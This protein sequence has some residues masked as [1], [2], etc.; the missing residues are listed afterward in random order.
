[1][2]NTKTTG[3]LTFGTR[4][5]C[6]DKE[7][8][9]L[10]Y[11]AVDPATHQV[12][13]IVAEHG[14]PFFKHNRVLPFTLI[15]RMAADA[16]QLTINSAQWDDYQEYRE[17]AIEEPDP[18]ASAGRQSI[19]ADGALDYRVPMIHRRLRQGIMA[20]RAI[21]HAGT[22]VT[23]R[24]PIAHSEAVA[25]QVD[26][27]LVEETTGRISHLALRRGLL[28]REYIVV[29]IDHLR[30][31]G[32][33]L[34]RL[35]A[36]AALIDELPHYQ[37]PGEDALLVNVEQQLHEESAAFA[38]VHATMIAS[39]LHLTGHVRSREL[40]YHASELAR[41]TPGVTDVQNDIR[42]GS[43]IT[44]TVPT[45]TDEA[46]TDEVAAEVR[47]ALAVDARTKQH[48][49]AVTHDDGVIALHGQVNT[50]AERQLAESLAASQPGVTAVYNE[51]TV[52]PKQP[53]ASAPI[54]A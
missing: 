38:A 19:R 35:D 33:S 4:V 27:L 9:K 12:T 39:V 16:I 17:V 36:T 34:I 21:L 31:D 2:P 7:C 48:A 29:P 25:G 52:Q 20:E 37:R 43:D 24:D 23:Q 54:T 44:A 50:I 40:K 30:I 45:P 11:V 47:Y 53:T 1:M 8:G 41:T 15:E 3:N 13:E 49:I 51:L 5:Y 22:P 28:Q 26:H 46:P 18:T 32:D 10:A 14:L 42:V 6:T